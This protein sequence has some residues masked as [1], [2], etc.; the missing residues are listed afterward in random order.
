M[1]TALLHRK[2]KAAEDAARALKESGGPI[3]QTRRVYGT[4]LLIRG[5]L[6]ASVY[7]LSRGLLELLTTSTPAMRVAISLLPTPFFAYYLWT[8]MKGVSEMD[9]LERR[10]ELE[11]LGFAFPASLVFLST[12]GLLDVA[13]TLNP[14][15]FSL[16]HTWLML[17]MLYYIGLW[18]AKRRYQ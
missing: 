14:D 6:W 2:R 1:L 7:L 12:L 9:E 5:L 8:W 3:E 16:R 13:I 15:D 11:A 17:P 18:R 10:I 4:R